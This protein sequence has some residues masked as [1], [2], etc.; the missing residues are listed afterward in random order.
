MSDIN[1]SINVRRNDIAA[2]IECRL[3]AVPVTISED[4]CHVYVLFQEKLICGVE[5]KENVYRIFNASSEWKEKTTYICQKDGTEKWYYFVDT[6]D[7]V[8]EEVSRLVVFEATKN[9]SNKQQKYAEELRKNVTLETFKEAYIRFI[10]QADENFLTGKGKG[11]RTPYGFSVSKIYG[12]N[13]SQHFGQGAASKTPYI[14]WHVV[15]VY[16][17]PDNGK[18]VIG[19]EEQRYKYI[20]QMKPKKYT[21]LGNKSD[22]V[23]IFY[24]T[25][26]DNVD[27]SELYN[28][29]IKV[30]DEVFSLGLW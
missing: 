10:K 18:I 4:D 9:S 13:L 11:S 2:G 14:N 25:Y 8:I 16:Y 15:S 26:K 30:S 28:E 17:L 12:C 7:E 3:K 21:Q 27:Y 19:I 22:R 1:E 29:F 5:V 20:K 24:E 23:A 6:A